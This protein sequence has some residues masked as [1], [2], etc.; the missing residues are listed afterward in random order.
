M[1]SKISNGVKISV[2]T[3]YNKLHSTKNQHFFNYTISIENHS[4]TEIKLIRR[5]WYV[6]DSMNQKFIVEGL[7]VIGEQPEFEKGELYSYT[8]GTELKGYFGEMYGQYQFLNINTGELFFVE[9]PKFKLEVP[10]SLN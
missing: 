6:F 4:D 1:I 2:E 3:V 7:G 9:I 5:K 8:S 10:Y